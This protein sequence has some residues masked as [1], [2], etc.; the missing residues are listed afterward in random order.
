MVDGGGGVDDC[1][2]L[3]DVYAQLARRIAEDLGDFVD[4][5]SQLFDA[6]KPIAH[7]VHANCDSDDPVQLG[8][9]RILNQA[10]NDFLDLLYESMSGRGRPAVRSARSL[11]EHM[12]NH[13]WISAN[14]SEAERYCD[15]AAMAE[16]LNLDLNTPEAEEFTGKTRKKVRHWRHKLERRIRPAAALAIDKYGPSFRRSWTKSSLLNRA[17]SVGAGAD[18]DV[19]RLLS[20]VIHGAAGGDLGHRSEIDGIQ[21]VRTGPAVSICPLALQVGLKFYEMLVRQIREAVDSV[22][23]LELEKLLSQLSDLVPDHEKRCTAVDAEIW[24]GEAPVS[25][26]YLR[27][28]LDGTR[29][30]LLF[31]GVGSTILADVVGA[32]SGPNAVWL[33]SLIAEVEKVNPDRTQPLLIGVEKCKGVPRPGEKWRPA[34]ETLRPVDRQSRRRP[35]RVKEPQW[36]PWLST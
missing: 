35:L 30:W 5:Q 34:E 32:D 29:N 7:A 18:Y 24:P 28:E 15:H 12:V 2:V 21:V 9:S 31:D 6:W 19:Y 27:V 14:P 17:Q 3:F 22:V 36:D 23:T 20:A 33:E 16:L 26:M 11:F 10:H 8:R 13:G 25:V 1:G 4:I